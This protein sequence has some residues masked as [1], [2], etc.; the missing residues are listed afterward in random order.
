LI[1]VFEH[2][3]RSEI[4]KQHTKAE[5]T[6]AFR[7]HN[8]NISTPRVQ[9]E[10]TWGNTN[11]KAFKGINSE[12]GDVSK[13]TL[14]TT[15]SL[16][17]GDKTTED[18]TIN[19]YHDQDLQQLRSTNETSLKKTSWN[20][21]I[22]L[23]SAQSLHAVS[24]HE[25]RGLASNH[26]NFAFGGDVFIPNLNYSPPQMVASSSFGRVPP[27]HRTSLQQ[28]FKEGR[29]YRAHR[30]ESSPFRM[31]TLK[32]SAYSKFATPTEE[33]TNLQ[34][35]GVS[36]DDIN[37][38]KPQG[39]TKYVEAARLNIAS[40]SI[41]GTIIPKFNIYEDDVS[42]HIVYENTSHNSSTTASSIQPDTAKVDALPKTNEHWSAHGA[43]VLLREMIGK[44][45]AGV[46]DVQPDGGLYN[47]YV[48]SFFLCLFF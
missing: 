22:S 19:H 14:L 13:E 46:H 3:W 2:S 31:E 42:E 47:R 30:F 24:Q 33:K 12:G 36:I 40:E 10:S 15:S 26:D 32:P 4:D 37:V 29:R 8:S 16:D 44:Y 39:F 5:T 21:H 34:S 18:I 9:G 48:V 17:G 20:R 11:H 38:S 1:I 43:E 23:P 41:K 25:N 6:M 28:A 27:N 45:K 35:L 7:L